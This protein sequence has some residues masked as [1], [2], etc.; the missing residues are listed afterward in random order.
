MGTGHTYSRFLVHVAFGTKDRQ[1]RIKAE[2][3]ERLYR[4][5]AGVAKDEFGRLI[6]VGGTEDHVHV[7]V[8][9]SLRTDVSVATAM[10]K[11]KS[12]SSGWVHATFPDEAAFG[13]QPGY[14]AFS[15]SESNAESVVRYIRNQK[16]HHERQTFSEESA[17]LLRKHGIDPETGRKMR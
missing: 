5:M 11:L 7:H 4:Y 3:R 8:L 17:A 10:R 15:V 1:A 14:G 12:L 16:K 6:E 2:F 13:W 9:V